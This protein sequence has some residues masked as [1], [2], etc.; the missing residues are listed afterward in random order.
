M[1]FPWFVDL[2]GDVASLGRVGYYS[3]YIGGERSRTA[4]ELSAGYDFHSNASY[5]RNFVK[6]IFVKRGLAI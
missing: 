3:E 1:Y 5:Q 2:L 4:D 6:R